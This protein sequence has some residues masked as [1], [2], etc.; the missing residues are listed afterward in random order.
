MSERLSLKLGYDAVKCRERVQFGKYR[1]VKPSGNFVIPDFTCCKGLHESQVLASTSKTCLVSSMP[2]KKETISNISDDFDDDEL[3]RLADATELENFPTPTSSSAF[4]V[5]NRGRFGHESAVSAIPDPPRYDEMYL[6]D[7]F[8]GKE[9]EFHDSPNDFFDADME[10]DEI[11]LVTNNERLVTCDRNIGSEQQSSVEIVMLSPDFPPLKSE[12]TSRALLYNNDVF[13]DDMVDD[14]ME[15]EAQESI[16]PASHMADELGDAHLLSCNPEKQR[17]DMHGQFRAFLQDDGDQFEDENKHLGQELCNEMYHILKSKF[18][19]NQFRH[20]QKHA[21]IAALLGYDCFILMPTGAGKSLCYQLPAVLSKGVTVVISPLKSLIEDQKMKM[22]ELEVCCYALTSELSQAESDRI[23]GMLN[24][25][26][27]KI[28]LLY[29]TPEKIAASEK[30]NNVF[31]SLHRRGLLT[32]FVV[33]EAHCVS[34]WGHDFRPDYRKLQSLRRM[35]TDPMVPIM[36]LTATATPKIVTDTRV[37][38]AIQQSKLFIS[39]FVRTNLKYDVIAKGPRSLVRVMDRMKILYPGKSGIIYCL[40][41]KDCES[42]S[43]MLENQTI[44]SEVYHAGLSDKKRLEVQTKWINNRVDVICATIAFGMGIDKPDVRYVIHFSMPKS[45]EGYY[46]ETG[47]AGRDGLNS[48]C[49]ILY[50]YNDSI[51]IRKMIEGENNTQGVRTMH[52][53]SVLQIVAYCENVSICRRKLLVEHFGEVYDAEACR[54]SDS[55]CD[56]CVQ[57]IKNANGYKVYDMTEEAKLVAQSMLHMHNVTLKYLADLY[58]GHMGQKKFADT[59]VRLGH[60]KY[61]MYGRG[62]G[63]QEMDA[64]RFVRKLVI[65]G[66]IT[67]QLYNTKF[68]TTVSYAELT[69]LGR[70]LASGRSRMKVYL[71]ISNQPDSGRRSNGMEVTALMSINSV[72]EVEA[73]KEKHMVK[74]ADLFSKCKGDLLRLFSDI[75]SAEGLSNHQPIINSEG[76][77]QIAALMPRTYSD[78]L[79]IDSMTARKAE[80]YGAQIMCMLKEYWNELD[81]REENEIKRQL[82]HMNMNKD[83][84]GGFRDIQIDGIIVPTSVSN[85]QIVSGRGKYMPYFGTPARSVQSGSRRGKVRKRGFNGSQTSNS[86]R[87]ST[88]SRHGW[89]KTMSRTMKAPINRSLFPNL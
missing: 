3:L 41:R 85:S 78:L 65:D 57:Q 62:V 53:S 34:Q 20:R 88:R 45:I 23:Y 71:H 22:K 16:H 68:D 82:N 48:Y 29:V 28:K 59:A 73:L 66:I 18:G 11:L 12:I 80:R 54:T 9:I 30:L 81:A 83:I 4:V 6:N 79:Q 74:H 13:D 33:D 44:S 77:E 7:S 26:S 15:V 69:D 63:M 42:V 39:S 49:A 5:E 52:L 17:H 72:S 55:P 35:F 1:F 64:L 40:S 87:G 70:E 21:I 14:N 51:R 32:R 58:R 43:K 84:V 2:Q 76:I 24:E 27:P 38:L 86:S 37:H 67:E 8:D 19:F 25:S 89:K 47:R 31:F 75:A 60:T 61:A 50:N 46:Q 56:I 36:A 10:P